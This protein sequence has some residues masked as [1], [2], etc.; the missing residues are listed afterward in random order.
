MA[1]KNILPPEEAQSQEPSAINHPPGGLQILARLI[2]HD[3]L[4]KRSVWDKKNN[5]NLN[6]L[7]T[8]EDS[9]EDVS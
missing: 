4:T 1:A 9:N 6:V 8:S 5:A 2:A 3:L 7:S